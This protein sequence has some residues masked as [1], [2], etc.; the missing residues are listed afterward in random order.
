[1]SKHEYMCAICNLSF[2]ETRAKMNLSMPIYVKKNI[3]F[4]DML[5]ENGLYV[6]TH[7]ILFYMIIQCILHCLFEK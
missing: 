4:T 3:Q 7:I 6:F 5:I 2:F 1:M